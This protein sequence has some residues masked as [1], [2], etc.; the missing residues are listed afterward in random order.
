[1][2]AAMFSASVVLAGLRQIAG[3][4]VEAACPGFAD[5]ATAAFVV[6]AHEAGEKELGDG[7]NWVLVELQ[8]LVVND[9]GAAQLVNTDEERLRLAR[10]AVEPADGSNDEDCDQSAYDPAKGAGGGSVR[11]PSLGVFADVLFVHGELSSRGFAG[12]LRCRCAAFDG[13]AGSNRSASDATACGGSTNKTSR[14]FRDFESG[15]QGGEQRQD[16]ADEPNDGIE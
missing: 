6:V 12:N 16:K 2:T 4:K 9:L 3:E 7:G 13:C 14:N 1:M 10:S 8:G 5:A 11:R 15:E